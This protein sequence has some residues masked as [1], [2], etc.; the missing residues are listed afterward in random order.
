MPI[1][2]TKVQPGDLIT[3]EFMNNLIDVCDDLQK[4]VS[5]LEEPAVAPAGMQISALLPSGRKR[6]GDPLYIIGQGFDVLQGNIVTIDG[7]GVTA[8]AGAD[9]D[10]EIIV[11][12]P[13]I[14]GVTTIGKS[15]TALVS[16]ARG[17]D[18]EDFVLFPAVETAL[19]G[20]LFVTYTQP[21]PDATL[22]ASQSYT[23]LYSVQAL[24][25]LNETYT[26]TATVS[27]GWAAQIVDASDVPITP[28]E[29]TLPSAPP[30]AGATQTIRVRVSIPAGTADRTSGVLQLTVTSQRNPTRVVDGSPGEEIV[31]G[32]APPS[33]EPV[34]ITLG[35]VIRTNASQPSAT[36][37]GNVVRIGASVDNYRFT[38]SAQIEADTVY[39]VQIDPS[40]DGRWTTSLSGTDPAV[41][42]QNIGPI[43]AAANQPIFV[44]VRA[45]VGAPDSGLTLRL[46]STTDPTETGHIDQSIGLLP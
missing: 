36:I 39:N 12:I 8:V 35:N 42:S 9:R 33:P 30:P 37:T 22:E 27:A 45:T 24:T 40:A 15:V 28:A 17:T 23:F 2:P 7:I 26:A 20:Q 4:R 38:F 10:R 34:S 6:I 14:Q 3:H 31:V 43:D 41:T 46:T 19:E 16:N 13:N 21:P 18:M 44:W 32:A 29:I 25:N 5:R 11:M 1:L